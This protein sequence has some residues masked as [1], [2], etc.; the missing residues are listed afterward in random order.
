MKVEHILQAKG[1]DV[2]AVREDDDIGVAV[3][4][5]NDKNI[6]AVVVRDAS[7]GVVGILSE[8]DVVRQLGVNGPEA[9]GMRVKDCMTPD[10]FT[11]SPEASVDD[12]MAQ[13]TEKRVRH[14]PVTAQGKVVGVV[15]IGD[16]VKRK[17]RQAEQEA[18]A[19][20]D[21]IAS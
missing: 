2:F 1:T 11:C 7:E 9:L 18:Q 13:M 10:P 12:L 5:L 17:I 19:L 8:R 20:K 3:A 6:G 4:L 14:L 16:V 15:S 21:Y